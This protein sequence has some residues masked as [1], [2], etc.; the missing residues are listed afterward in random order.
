MKTEA[1]EYLSLL[2]EIQNTNVTTFTLIPADEPRFTIETNSRK[3]TV[4][5]EFSFLSVQ[6]DHKAETIYFEIDRYFDD[7]DLSQ[8]TCIVQFINKNGTTLKEGTYPVTT[9]DVDSIEGKIVFGWKI[10]N[11]ATQLTGDITFSVRFYSIDENS[12]FTYNFNTLTASS[13]ILPSLNVV[14]T[15]EKITA[16][17]LEVWT[18][19]MNSLASSIE[20][21]IVT[22]EEKIEELENSIASIPEDYSALTEE[23]SQLSLDIEENIYTVPPIYKN[24]NYSGN[25]MLYADRGGLLLPC[26]ENIDVSNFK[27]KS[28]KVYL[29]SFNSSVGTA[30]FRISQ[31]DDNG[32]TIGTNILFTEFPVN[33]TITIAENA[34]YI[35]LYIGVTYSISSNTDTNITYDNL[36]IG[37][38][39]VKE[40][41]SKGKIGIITVAKSGGDYT[42]ISEAVANANDSSD[43]PI[44]IML[45]PGTYD[46]HI[47]LLDRHISIIGVNRDTCIIRDD[48]GKYNNDPIKISG[49]VWR[50]EN[51]TLISTHKN[52]G[53]WTPSWTFPDLPSYALHIDNGSANGK[54]VVKN[55]YL[56]SENLN[57][58]GA[59]THNG[60]NVR[61][62]NCV[63]VRNTTDNNYISSDYEGAVACH[64]PNIYD[65]T[66]TES[67]FSMYNN[68]ITCNLDKA[69][70]L[71]A[72]STGCK[73]KCVMVGNT[74]VANNSISDVVVYAGSF[75]D[76][77]Y[78]L[79]PQ[80]HGNSTDEL[81]A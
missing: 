3:I 27:G 15:G 2:Q 22:V 40:E 20:V 65:G 77:S 64:S 70:Q 39:T 56:Y 18:T 74:L 45:Y 42:T 17:E 25:G 59:G 44:T 47:T 28:V 57:A 80:C 75:T 33:T 66:E 72:L 4:P 9:M 21:D 46:E 79:K 38:V 32:N 41:I 29:D 6:N 73:M 71:K 81:N 55:C 12:N 69:L 63:I 10:C 11:D 14:A 24:R 67:V 76:K 7:V 78:Y 37:G 16:S 8:H 52:S 43:N 36:I 19:K 53:S 5:S 50:L 26:S 51:L 61:I 30:D 68:E 31:G 13:Y 34:S 62:E 1:S 35:K 54:G 48:S 23:V 60:E 49:G 58:I